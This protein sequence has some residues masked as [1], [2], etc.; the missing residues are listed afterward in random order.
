MEYN[1]MIGDKNN[2]E[3]ERERV[4]WSMTCISTTTTHLVVRSTLLILPTWCI[5]YYFGI[6]EEVSEKMH[7]LKSSGELSV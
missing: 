4:S 1:T 7:K 6:Y 5:L 3:R 2:S